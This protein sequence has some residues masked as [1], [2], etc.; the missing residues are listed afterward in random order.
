MAKATIL[1]V[2]G[3]Q[4]IVKLIALYLKKD[5][6]RILPAYDGR[7]AIELARRCQPDLILVDVLLPYID[8]LEVCRV[9]RAESH[10]PVIMLA[11][12]ATGKDK[13][14]G[15]ALGADD[16][17]TMPFCLRELLARIQAALRRTMVRVPDPLEIALTA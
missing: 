1:V 8:G 14:A 11:S 16:Y 2:D 17:V 13:V 12:C 6:Y 4:E 10:V 9:L 15:L 3:D 7:K 5:G